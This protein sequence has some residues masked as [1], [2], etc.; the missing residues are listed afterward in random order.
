MA[1]P[2]SLTGVRWTKGVTRQGTQHFRLSHSLFVSG[3]WLP[4]CGS[5]LGAI[6]S[7]ATSLQE[8]MQIQSIRVGLIFV[9]PEGGKREEGSGQSNRP[10]ILVTYP[11]EGHLPTAGPEGPKTYVLLGTP[12]KKR[13]RNDKYKMR[14]T[15]EKKEEWE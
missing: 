11:G 10:V 3:A 8:D 9:Q 13:I 1:V 15:G 2:S 4:I 14:C 7:K 12:I 6:S 5:Q